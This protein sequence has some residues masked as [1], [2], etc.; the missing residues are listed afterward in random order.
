MAAY[1]PNPNPNHR[2]TH[3]RARAR[4]RA[5]SNISD[6]SFATPQ[7]QSQPRRRAGVATHGVRNIRAE[8]VDSEFAPSI[9]TPTPLRIASL[10]A[11]YALPPT[12][13]S[14]F[15]G[16]L[17]ASLDAILEFGLSH[18]GCTGVVNALL[19]K[20]TPRTNWPLLLRDVY[21]QPGGRGMLEEVLF[22]VTRTLLPEQIAENRGLMARL[23][24]HKKQ[25]A[26]RLVLRYDMVR[27]WKAD[28]A[29][30]TITVASLGP[31]GSAGGD[32][33]DMGQLRLGQRRPFRQNVIPTLIAAPQGGWTTHAVRERMKHHVTDLDGYLMLSDEV[34]AGWSDQVLLVMASQIV[35]Q[36]QWVRNNNEILTEMEIMGYEEFEGRADENDWMVDDVRK[37]VRAT[38]RSGKKE[39]DDDEDFDAK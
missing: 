12:V 19:E 30:H 8:T 33:I 2:T 1:N 36:W 14:P 27:E 17:E 7:P 16:T 9:N 23:Y 35:L 21:V 20:V 11:H 39:K 10:P 3:P 18:V 37:R 28:G 31:E 4:S 13:P 34:V 32:G 29:G 25:L 6:S 22:L 5:Y 24:E 15:A 38:E 26:I